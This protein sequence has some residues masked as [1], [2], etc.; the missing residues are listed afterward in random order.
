MVENDIYD[1]EKRYLAFKANLKDFA[2]KPDAGKR[3]YYCKNKANLA[4][5]KRLF[6]VFES[7]DISYVRRNKLLGNF[8]LICYSTEKNLK[9]CSR[10]DINSTVAQMHQLYDS[11]KSK[12]DF[13]KDLKHIW[14]ITFPEKDEKG[15]EDEK[16]VP[17]VVRHLSAKMDKSK[18]KLRG[19]RLTLEEYDK[20][21]A[22]FSKN[23]MMQAFIM[24]LFESLGRPQEVLYTK[25]KDVDLYD[26]YAKVHISEHGK[27]G[28]GFL[29]CIDSYPYISRWLNL[30]PFRKNPDSFLFVNMDCKSSGEQFKPPNANKKIRKACKDLGINKK[31]TC[32]S[33]K[34]NGVTLRR[35]R[36]DTDL[37]IQH[38]ARWN[39]TRQ[40]KTYDQSNQEDALKREL[41]K[42]GI[43][44][45]EDGVYH[46]QPK[47]CAFCNAK[48]GFSDEICP[49]CARPLDRKKIIEQE[50]QKD[51]AM[52]EL[53]AELD[54]I[55]K[56]LETRKPYEDELAEFF[57]NQEVKELYK[58][59]YRKKLEMLR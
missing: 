24:L 7:Q 4:H 14:R 42:R 53:K 17:Y 48:A 2:H 52:N 56:Q 55:K 41:V 33:F 8:K 11:P 28:C 30:H 38:A 18:E 40:L 5:F 29:Q 47:V 43:I 34:R 22:Y 10:E 9:D 20:I 32:Y 3:K 59:M 54:D 50:K 6:D 37:D 57:R 44:K 19:D 21:V 49:N 31:I 1:N 26:N 35:L 39:S 36:G 58:E 27:E 13:I 45:D 15:R 25:I 51:T 23:P 16:A 12:A 46:Q